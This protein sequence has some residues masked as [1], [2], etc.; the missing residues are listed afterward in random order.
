[1]SSINPTSNSPSSFDPS[2]LVSCTDTFNALFACGGPAHQFDRYYKDGVLDGCGRELSEMMLCIKLKSSGTD[3]E[4][5]ELVK[6]LM[7][8]KKSTTLDIVWQRA[9]K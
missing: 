3:A 4:K 7:I 1:M 6:Q 5:R 2:S 8:E 9:D